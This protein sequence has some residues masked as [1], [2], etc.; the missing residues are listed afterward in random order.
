MI[1]R[2]RASTDV[3]TREQRSHCMSRIRGKDTVPEMTLRRALWARG[4]RYR[5]HYRI[6]GRPDIVF[7][8]QKTA[9]F[10]DGCFWHGCP[11]HRTHPKNNADFWRTKIENNIARDADVTKILEAEGWTVL[12]F[13]EHQIKLELSSIVDRI[14]LVLKPPN[15]VDFQRGEK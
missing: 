10:I 6:T 3:M 2:K 1:N 11:A 12:R 7:P 14:L 4:L 5:L 13:W 9:I 15:N 8:G